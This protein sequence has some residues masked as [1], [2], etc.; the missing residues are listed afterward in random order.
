MHE[1]T[2]ENHYLY[3]PQDSTEIGIQYAFSLK[4]CVFFKYIDSAAKK[5]LASTVKYNLN[6]SQY[7]TI[8]AHNDCEFV[9]T[10][11]VLFYM[12]S[13]YIHEKQ[14]SISHEFVNTKLYCIILV[15]QGCHPPVMINPAEEL[16]N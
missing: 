14:A 16:E 6:S 8:C 10:F 1:D 4:E 3:L 2:H 11:L 15:A 9:N 12:L 5:C 7:L 13:S